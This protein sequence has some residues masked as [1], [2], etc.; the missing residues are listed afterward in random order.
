MFSTLPKRN[1]NFSITFNLSSANALNFDQS[2]ILSFGT[3]K[4]L[5]VYLTA[6]INSFSNK[7]LFLRVCCTSPLKTLQE[8]EKLLVMGNFSFY[9]SVFYLLNNF[10]PFS[11]TLKFSSAN[12]F[13]LEESKICHLGK[14][15]NLSNYNDLKT[16]NY[17]LID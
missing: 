5:I 15:Q 4:D 1:I 3:C 14:G 2:K 16:R 8:K 9:Y 10:L 6:K 13:S 11:S 7:T 12:S 17:W